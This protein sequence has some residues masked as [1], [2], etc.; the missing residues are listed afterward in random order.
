VFTI[1]AFDDYL[2][3]SSGTVH[4]ASSFLREE[5]RQYPSF[6][7]GNCC[8]FHWGGTKRVA[9]EFSWF[10]WISEPKDFKLYW[11]LSSNAIGTQVRESMQQGCQVTEEPQQILKNPWE[12][13]WWLH[14]MW[15]R[16]GLK[17]LRARY[18]EG[19]LE[20]Q[21]DNNAW[22]CCNKVGSLDG[23]TW[24]R[25]QSM[26][27]WIELVHPHPVQ[28]IEATLGIGICLE[29]SGRGGGDD[30]VNEPREF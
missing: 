17:L 10:Y 12:R 24:S 6:L 15:R 1:S 2:Y 4:E 20:L 11:S 25:L 23:L 5:G 8:T 26:F 7:N 29:L 3:S 28:S 22:I 27:V 19:A 30:Q 18:L 21:G 13:L 14:Q 9:K 16:P